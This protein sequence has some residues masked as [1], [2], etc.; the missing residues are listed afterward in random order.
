MIVVDDASTDD[1]A[2]LLAGYGDAGARRHA[3]A[4]TAASPRACNDGAAAA[5]R[6]VPRLPQQRHDPAAPAGSTRS[7][8]TPTPHPAGGGRRQQAAVPE[9]HRPA[10]RRRRLPGRLPAPPLRRLPGRPSG[11]QQVAPLPGRDR[12]LHARAA[13]GLRARPAAST[14]PFATRSRTSTSACASASAGHEVHYCPESV[15]LP[16]RVG[17]ARPALEGDRSERRGCSRS[18][19]ASRRERDDLRYYVE[20]GLL[21]IALPRPLPAQDRARPRARAVAAGPDLRPLHRAPVRAGRRPAARDRAADRARRRP[22]AGDRAAR[23]ASPN[24]GRRRQRGRKARRRGLEGLRGGR[25]AAAARHP[26]LPGEHRRGDRGSDAGANGRPSFTPGEVS[27][28]SSSKRAHATR[29]SRR[30]CLRARR[31]LVVSRGDEQPARPRRPPGWHFPQEDDGTYAGRHP[32]DSDEAIAQLE[33][34]REQ[35]RRLPA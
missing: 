18:A 4:R 7:S 12:R 14:P 8:T 27:P 23:D 19:G 22:R 3:A 17:L 13:R 28:T 29:S 33:R 34:L 9:R 35:R 16:P 5:R 6:R 24:G 20:D 32:A 2:E 31:S 11:R 15:A 25:G 26:C 10:R 30:P 21:R 1:T